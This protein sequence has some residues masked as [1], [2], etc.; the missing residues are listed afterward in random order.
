[1][2]TFDEDS[3]FLLNCDW[4]PVYLESLFSVEFD[5]YSD[6]WVSNM[7]DTEFLDVVQ[8]IERYSPI[9]EDISMDDNELC[10][11]VEQIETE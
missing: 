2:D 5:D 8:S 10:M 1:M 11:A 4:D 6:L 3:N 9:V 7:N